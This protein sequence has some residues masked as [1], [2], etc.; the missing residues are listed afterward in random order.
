MSLKFTE[1]MIFCLALQ[2]MTTGAI[3]GFVDVILNFNSSSLLDDSFVAQFYSNERNL[4]F[5]GDEVWLRLFPGHFIRS[6]G[7]TSFFV[8]D[9]T[10]ACCSVI[11]VQFVSLSIAFC[12]NNNNCNNTGNNIQE[13]TRVAYRTSNARAPNS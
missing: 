8:T 1:Y 11:Q 7:T 6:D 10:E 4:V 13:M 3:P 12:Q 9:Y 5:Y 2:A